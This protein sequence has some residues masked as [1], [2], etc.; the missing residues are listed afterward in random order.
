MARVVFI[1]ATLAT[2]AAT[3]AAATVAT[4]AVAT[5]TGCPFGHCNGLRHA[6][7]VGVHPPY[8]RRTL[9]LLLFSR[10]PIYPSP[11][12]TC[13]FICRLVLIV[14]LVLIASCLAA[15][16]ARELRESRWASAWEVENAEVEFVSY[17]APNYWNT[18]LLNAKVLHAC[19]AIY[20][21]VP[22]Y[23]YTSILA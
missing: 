19:A 12:R 8:H 3:A 23:Q 5:A 9:L 4:A 22:V 20:N 14:R 11:L 17:N 1:T 21:S 16:G 6:P 2:A 13:R 7:S 10:R 18:I 15:H